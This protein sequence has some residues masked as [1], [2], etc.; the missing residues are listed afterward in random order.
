M[1]CELAGS[2]P[3]LH[4]SLQGSV[5]PNLSTPPPSPRYAS[6]EAAL[7]ATLEHELESGVGIPVENETT[8]DGMHAPCVCAPPSWFFMSGTSGESASKR[9]RPL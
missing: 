4:A 9:F 8:L 5:R 2:Q 7:E 1:L 6:I 3:S